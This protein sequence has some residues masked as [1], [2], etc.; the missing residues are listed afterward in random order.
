[1]SASSLALRLAEKALATRFE[2]LDPRVV[3]EVK[4]RMLD[5]LGCALGAWRSGP[6]RVTREAAAA[7]S[8]PGG[9]SLFGSKHRTTPDLAAFSNGALVRYLDFNDT[10][11]SLEPAHPS[12][13]IP[14]CLAVG[15]SSGADGRRI[16]AAI[17][18]AYELQCRLCDA[19]S[20]RKHGWDH[21]CY[22][23]F[24]SALAAGYLYGLDADRMVHALGIAGVSNFATRQT[25]TGQLSMWKA[26]A[27]S[28]AARN[29]V[30]A[31]D[32]ARRG[33]TGPNE[34]FE[35]PKGLFQMITGPFEPAWAARGDDYMILKTYIKFWPAEYHS[36]SAIDACLQLR[37]EVGDPSAIESIRVESF[38]AAVS[39]IGS[40]PEKWRPTSRE[41][42]DHSMGFC[43]ACALI[44]GDVTR[45][46]FSEDK[47]RDP[48]ILA[49]LDK[50]RIVETPECNAGYPD[51]IPN[52]VIIRTADGRTL[53]RKVN[54]P[55]GHAGNPMTDD[56]VVAKFKRQADGIVSTSTADRIIETAMRFERVGDAAELIEFT[57]SG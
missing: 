37:P 38:E 57:V 49:L 50:I 13:N 15:Q 20:L 26:C 1:M 14:A 46:S 4:R 18:L 19:A 41:T 32:L 47:I 30:F 12:D 25:R 53:T 42:A 51:G 7:V 36:Q 22:G 23:A 3:H 17:A 31:A 56:E 10:Y 28:N 35:G 2:Q 45:G 5:S 9:A 11:L 52:K 43:M 40:E 6:A 48:R 29:G 33:M 16:I 54:Y 34:I 55:R 27:F 21:V 24:S 44:D 8:V 39:I